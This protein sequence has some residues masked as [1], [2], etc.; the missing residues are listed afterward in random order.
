MDVAALAAT[1]VAMQAAQLQNN[2]GIS[3]LK[4]QQ[5][6]DQS[7]ISMID[8]AIQSAP[9]PLPEGVGTKIDKTA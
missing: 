3:M 8:T 2:V 4:Q 9:A 7:I 6:A 1:A 5:Q